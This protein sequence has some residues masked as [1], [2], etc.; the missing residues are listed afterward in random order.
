MR[1]RYPFNVRQ[2]APRIPTESFK[3]SWWPKCEDTNQALIR[4]IT[5]KAQMG[6]IM[7]NKS[8]VRMSRLLLLTV[9]G[10]CM[11][12]LTSPVSPRLIAT[13]SWNRSD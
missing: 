7:L 11:C 8:T 13:S 2:L 6:L 10:V 1:G 9:Y 3:G 4:V 5:G 12:E